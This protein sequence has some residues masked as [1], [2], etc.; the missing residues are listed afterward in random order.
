MILHM[1]LPPTTR[2]HYTKFPA[3]W[4]PYAVSKC[5]ENDFFSLFSAVTLHISERLKTALMR[6]SLISPV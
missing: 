5:T 6:H 2:L 1:G 3:V 4:G